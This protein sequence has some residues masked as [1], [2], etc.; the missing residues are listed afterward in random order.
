MLTQRET[1]APE[2][3]KNALTL[4]PQVQK[5]QRN[6]SNQTG[7]GKTICHMPLSHI[8]SV[9]KLF[10]L[11]F[12]HMSSYHIFIICLHHVSKHVCVFNLYSYV[13][14][15]VFVYIVFC[16]FVLRSCQCLM[17]NLKLVDCLLSQSEKAADI[18]LLALLTG[19][20]LLTSSH[21]S[22][23]VTQQSVRKTY[24]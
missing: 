1:A 17:S 4:C 24:F 12:L 21:T 8:V 10:Y 19:N 7:L 13:T 2:V 23:L 9:D 20:L 14:I 11:V 15:H 5:E 6:C 3:N 22:V 18:D 16:V